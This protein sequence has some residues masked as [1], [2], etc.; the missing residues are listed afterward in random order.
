VGGTAATSKGAACSRSCSM[1]RLEEQP[2]K[3]LS[4]D[5]LSLL[6]NGQSFSDVSFAVEGRHV[7]A[8]KCVLAA[9]SPFFRM[10]FCGDAHMLDGAPAV[11]GSTTQQ[12]QPQPPRAA[13]VAPQV[14]PVGIVGHDVFM[15]LLQFLYTGNLCFSPQNLSRACKEKSCWHTHCSSA[16]EFALET[17]NAAHFFG[18][19]QL[20][21]LTQVILLFLSLLL[22]L[23]AFE[24]LQTSVLQHLLCLL[25]DLDILQT[26]VNI[27]SVSVS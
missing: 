5:F 13:T 25:L 17:L 26:S 18:V 2:L 7:Y 16:V 27:S 15:L 14:I 19:D 12:Q 24:M 6:L 3:S 1:N 4:Q 8:H 10:I 9:R 20:S 11:A 22:L 21:T 23:I